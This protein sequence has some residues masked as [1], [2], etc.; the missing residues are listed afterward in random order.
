M[1]F[2]LVEQSFHNPC[3]ATHDVTTMRTIYDA[4]KVGLE[5]FALWLWS[6]ERID[7][8]LDE[9]SEATQIV[10]AE[11]VANEEQERIRSELDMESP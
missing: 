6:L 5:L 7:A 11:L 8:I 1:E 4:T 9:H 2:D 3:L 10:H